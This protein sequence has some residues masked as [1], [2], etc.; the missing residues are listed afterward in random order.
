[1]ADNTVWIKIRYDT[2]GARRDLKQLDSDLGKVGKA[3]GGKGTGGTGGS[4]A[5]STPAT[6]AGGSFLPKSAGAA[7]VPTDLASLASKIVGQSQIG[8]GVAAKIEHLVNLVDAGVKAVN[9]L[10]G[11]FGLDGVIIPDE[12][13]GAFNAALKQTTDLAGKVAAAGGELSDDQLKTTLEALRKIAERQLDAQER[14]NKLLAPKGG[15]GGG[16]RR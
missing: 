11:K 8:Q 12:K 16:G 3:G 1:M 15:L 14:A 5:K 6:A 9:Q 10:L 7:G 2:R 4:G 13:T